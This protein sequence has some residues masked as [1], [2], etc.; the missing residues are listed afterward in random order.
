MPALTENQDSNFNTE[1]ALSQAGGN[2]LHVDVVFDDGAV[3]LARLR[4][5]NSQIMPRP[6]QPYFTRSE[7]ATSLFLDTTAVAAPRTYYVDTDLG[8]LVATAFSLVEKLEGKPLYWYLASPAQKTK[9]M[10]Q[11]VEIYLELEKHPFD[12]TGSL[13]QKDRAIEVGA[14]A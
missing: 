3:W 12:K 1:P 10:Q 14:F 11:L 5:H 13:F 8:K 7:A 9:V 2:N 4:K 6:L